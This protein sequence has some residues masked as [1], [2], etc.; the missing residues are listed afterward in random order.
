MSKQKT[1]QGEITLFQ[2]TGAYE[3]QREVRRL[4]A[5]EDLNQWEQELNESGKRHKFFYHYT[6][7]DALRS[8]LCSSHWM[9]KK[10][11]VSND[12]TEYPVHSSSFT[13]SVL[14]SMGMWSQYGKWKPRKMKHTGTIGVRIAIPKDVF[15]TIFSGSV[16]YKNKTNK[17]AKEC[18]EADF[19][20]LENSACIGIA[21]VAYWYFGKDEKGTNDMLFYRDYIFPFNALGAYDPATLEKRDKRVSWKRPVPGKPIS[22][23]FKRAIWRS[24]NECRAYCDLSETA[25]IPD[26]VYVRITPEQFQKMRFILE[27]GLTYDETS[28]KCEGMQGERNLKRFFDEKLKEGIITLGQFRALP[29][30]EYWEKNEEDIDNQ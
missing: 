28:G 30:T 1:N 27:P 9:L 4:L 26:N 19:C 17:I 3:K 25:G 5:F 18:T 6:T 24:E 29:T 7:L 11:D 10:A 8:I 22:S 16:L 14:S 2:G 20:R 23:C 21:D 13:H 15:T 12:S